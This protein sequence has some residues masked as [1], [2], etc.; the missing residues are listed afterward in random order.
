MDCA[1][2]INFLVSNG[3]RM[4]DYWGDGKATRP[5]LPSI[6]VPTTAGTGSEAQSFAL[7]EQEGTLRKM[8]CGDEKVRFGAVI[9]DPELTATQ[10]R[11]VA[12]LTAMDAVSHV[13]ESFVT[14]RRNPVSRTFSR[15][16]WRLLS[17]AFVPAMG[18]QPDEATRGNFLVFRDARAPQI[19]DRL[20][21]T[22]I[23]VDCRDDRL[24]V[25]FG[26]HQDEADVDEFFRRTAT[27]GA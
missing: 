9:L 21:E 1:K 4:E 27:F 8:A 19:H 14:T 18:E 11:R 26:L 16:A 13:V 10:P 5:M 2:G 15:E 7:I 17:E 22:G 25:G 24:R 6:G 12:A 3:G 20:L 23:V